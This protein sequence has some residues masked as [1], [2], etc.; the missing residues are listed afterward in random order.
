MTFTLAL[1]KLV[2]SDKALM[3]ALLES[4]LWKGLLKIEWT[5]IK[6]AVSEHSIFQVSWETKWLLADSG[7]HLRSD[8][9]HILMPKGPL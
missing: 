6:R 5:V 1:G 2:E 7:T 4:Q 9:R 3:N 8:N